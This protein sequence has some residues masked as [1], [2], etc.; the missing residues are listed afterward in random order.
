[1]VGE[2]IPYFVI[3]LISFFLADYA[4]K[5]DSSF[6]CALV[7]LSLSVFVGLRSEEVGIDTA[8]Y[9]YRYS[10]CVTNGIEPLFAL[11][12]LVLYPFKSPSFFLFVCAL[13][14]YSLIIAR[15]WKMR[16]ILSFRYAVM[17]LVTA[18]LPFSMNLMRQFIAIGFVF[19]GSIFL[20]KRK[21]VFYLSLV[22][23]GSLFH[24]TALFALPLVYLEHFQKERSSWFDETLLSLFTLFA[25]FIALGVV[26]VVWSSGRMARYLSYL[27]FASNIGF[28]HF[29]RLVIYAAVGTVYFGLLKKGLNHSSNSEAMVTLFG[30][31]FAIS[32][33][34]VLL[35]T[36]GYV[37]SYVGRIAA[38]FE[39]YSLCFLSIKIDGK[40]E[41]Q[42]AM[43]RI[44]V[45]A[46]LIALYFQELVSNGNGVIPYELM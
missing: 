36:L 1:M 22:L 20:F 2:L 27:S 33:F 31:C 41:K 37:F 45:A 34:G 35:R 10:N 4:E 19:Y 6:F 11:M 3:L 38:Q 39:L 40:Y 5:K 12:I 43:I 13:I 23:L 28:T 44:L 8:Q 17:V 29:F 16:E 46:V 42:V 30:E 32:E 9:L 18:F 7:I 21:T 15:V 26:G 25:P 24:L 14:P